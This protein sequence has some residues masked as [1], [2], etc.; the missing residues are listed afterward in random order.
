MQAAEAIR[1]KKV[2][3][4]ELTKHIFERIDRFNP[5]L[6]A[7]VYQLR[8]EAMV[9]AKKADEGQA[10][11]DNHGVFHGV[12]IT[13]KES[14]GVAGHPATWGIPAF[15]DSRAA[16]NSDVVERL[17][18]DAGA[19]LVGATNVP[20]ALGDW[21]SYNPIYGQTNN[22]WDVKRTPGGSSGG[23][24][25]ALGSGIGISECWQRYRR[26]HPRACAL[27]WNFWT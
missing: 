23:S 7:F 6:N 3:S 26:F 8:D 17:L 19:V 1:S 18:S 10:R 4:V 15:R 12:P 14:F 13:I 16:K 9:A 11:G 24:A 25:A 21:Q 2:S 22:P 27:L 5:Q 20:V